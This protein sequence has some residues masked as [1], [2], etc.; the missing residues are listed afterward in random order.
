MK[1]EESVPEHLC[2]GGHPAISE[3]WLPRNRAPS[4]FK[5]TDFFSRYLVQSAGY[6]VGNSYSIMGRKEKFSS[7][8]RGMNVVVFD[9]SNGGKL[10]E[11]RYDTNESWDQSTELAKFIEE[12]PAGRIV[13]VAGF[14]GYRV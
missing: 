13:A 12:L 5:S 1:G 11:S 8:G 4:S 6:T 9:E 14:H 7:G 10:T 3:Y 2:S